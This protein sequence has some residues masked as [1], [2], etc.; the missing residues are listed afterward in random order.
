M[1]LPIDIGS[2]TNYKETF[3]ESKGYLINPE[4][5]LYLLPHV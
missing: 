4:D 2:V 3:A 1:H 5:Q